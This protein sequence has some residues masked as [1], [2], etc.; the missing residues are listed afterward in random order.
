MVRNEGSTST[1]RRCVN[2][3]PCKLREQ[4]NYGSNENEINCI[5][6]R[7]MYS[8]VSPLF[9]V[10]WR[11]YYASTYSDT[12]SECIGALEFSFITIQFRAPEAG[13]TFEA[14]KMVK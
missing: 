8:C 6:T 14:A 2:Y 10:S 7:F 5:V 11:I 9:R 4:A 12:V 13:V 3:A 1:V